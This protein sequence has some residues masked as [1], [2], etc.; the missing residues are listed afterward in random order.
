MPS[1]NLPSPGEKGYLLY[2]LENNDFHIVFKVDMA[3]ARV[4]ATTVSSEDCR[5]LETSSGKSLETVTL[6]D[7]RILGNVSPRYHFCFL[8]DE[9]VIPEKTTM[10]SYLFSI[11]ENVIQLTKADMYKSTAVL[12]VHCRSRSATRTRKIEAAPPKSKPA[13][14]DPILNPPP[15]P[16]GEIFAND[17][18]PTPPDHLPDPKSIPKADTDGMLADIFDLDYEHPADMTGDDWNLVMLT[19]SLLHGLIF[20]PKTKTM[21]V[22]RE[23]AFQL[24][25]SYPD[26]FKTPAGS[27]PSPTLNSIKE[28]HKDDK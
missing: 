18:D 2:L 16:S 22:A 1:D 21:V 17:D 6:A 20:D 9:N 28:G 7:L 12:A 11:K 26:S 8:G 3:D 5:K 25:H 13:P 24:K 14:P 19:N 15:K 23:P 4:K 10:V 27:T